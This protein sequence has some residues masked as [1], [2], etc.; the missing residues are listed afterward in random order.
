MYR[1]RIVLNEYLYGL[2]DSII[3]FTGRI[4]MFLMVLIDVVLG[5]FTAV[6]NGA[7]M[8]FID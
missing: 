2:T 3:V 4:D 1:D 7:I 6:V 8:V 5:L